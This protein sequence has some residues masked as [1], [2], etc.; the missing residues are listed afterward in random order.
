MRKKFLA[1]PYVVWMV[2][3]VIVPLF[4]VVG[5][6]LVDRTGAAFPMLG[7]YGHRTELQNSRPVWLADRPEYRR[8]GLA[9]ARLRFTTETAAECAAI[10]RGYLDGA[11]ARGE[12]TRGLYERGVE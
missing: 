11:P 8:M 9:Y 1:V 10:L 6:A 12:F 3:F 4:L 5:Y 2:V 7:V